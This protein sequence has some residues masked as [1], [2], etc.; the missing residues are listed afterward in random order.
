MAN[1]WHFLLSRFPSRLPRLVAGPWQDIKLPRRKAAFNR[2]Q[3]GREEKYRRCAAGDPHAAALSTGAVPAAAFASGPLIQSLSRR[4][5]PCR[6]RVPRVP[7]GRP[8]PAPRLRCAATAPPPLPAVAGSPWPVPLRGGKGGPPATAGQKWGK[9]KSPG[10]RARRGCC[11]RLE[12][13]RAAA[14]GGGDARLTAAARPGGHPWA[15]GSK[16]A[17]SLP[18]RAWQRP[19]WCAQGKEEQRSR[20]AVEERTG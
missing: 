16:R 18:G 20:G 5:L 11:R 2:K 9:Y 6:T 13:G 12:G 8:V 7:P 10:S 19:P 14:A 1:R 3:R 4:R 17:R 15:G